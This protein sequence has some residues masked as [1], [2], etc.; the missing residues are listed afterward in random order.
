MM[1]SITRCLNIIAFLTK[2]KIENNFFVNKT[3]NSAY[4]CKKLW[5]INPDL[6]C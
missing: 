5:Q 6:K 3:I 2:A 1:N 4:T